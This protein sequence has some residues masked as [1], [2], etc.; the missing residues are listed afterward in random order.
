M[1]AFRVLVRAR[2]TMARNGVRSAPVRHKVVF[3]A[4]AVF[5]LMLFAVVAVVCLALVRL[6]QGDAPLADGLSLAARAL[7]GRACEYLFF[8]LLA[9]SVPFVAATLFQS[10]DLPLLLASPASLHAIVAAKLLDSTV[11]NAAQF[12]VIGLP[13]L[14]GMGV[15]VQLNA[16]GW[17][18][19]VI[20]TLFLL[21]L[22]PCLVALLLLVAARTLGLARVR[23][24]VTLV[25]I[26]LAL[27]VTTLAVVGAS[28]ATQAGALERG[29]LTAALRGDVS[30]GEL[31]RA[32]VTDDAPQWLPS[33][34]VEI[35]LTDGAG[36]RNPGGQSAASLLALAVVTTLLVAAC[37]AIGP[38]ALSAETAQSGTA[39]GGGTAKRLP[40]LSA[41]LSGL[42]TKDAKYVARDTILLGQIGTALILF[43]VPFLLKLAA[44]NGPGATDKDL[45][46]GLMLAML[47]L[48]VYMVTSIVSLTS[49]GLEGRAAWIVLSSPVAR[50]AWLRAK[51]LGSFA[52]S[53]AV[54]VPLTLLSWLMF[55]W[56]WTVGASSLAVFIVA[57]F[58]L[59]G[60]G[61]GLAG[62]FPRFIYENPAHRA[63]VWALILGFV[64]ASA[65]L[66]VCGLLAALADILITHSAAPAAVAILTAVS[67]FLLL[68]LLTGILPVILAA[69]RMKN[70]EWEF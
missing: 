67:L 57:S 9:G 47:L 68:S 41:P 33:A 18:A 70:Y 65:Y 16:F 46:G 15:A 19:L 61:V 42:L 10:D 17:L 36:G 30:A 29:K 60:L 59:T 20:A 1:K 50:G 64:F 63:S 34:W 54:I 3:A 25:S 53:V 51:W 62:L 26:L 35:V 52:L 39:T 22:P 69:R 5:G 6:A 7:T 4:L 32:N 27:A 40:G 37:L 31:S 28:R 14:A 49:V 21:G 12:V 43:L 55:G 11:V 24:A 23:A 44:G 13:V 66:I 8:F 2:L 45:Y 56:S 58:A 38:D 48:I